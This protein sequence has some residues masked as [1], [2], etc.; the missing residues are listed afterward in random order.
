MHWTAR[1]HGGNTLFVLCCVYVNIN[2]VSVS[3]LARSLAGAHTRQQQV[4]LHYFTGGTVTPDCLV[5]RW[6]LLLLQHSHTRRHHDPGRHRQITPFSS[7]NLRP[8]AAFAPS[9]HLER[10]L[11]S[12][13]NKPK[14]EIPEDI[15]RAGREYY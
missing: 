11:A 13:E 12:E 7:T 6:A 5:T 2:C 10:A 15:A 14:I 1:G 9:R 8:H 3:P 4:Y